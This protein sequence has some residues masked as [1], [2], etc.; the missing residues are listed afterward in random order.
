MKKF[1]AIAAMAAMLIACGE[2]AEETPNN[3]GGNNNEGDNTE[4]E[5]V[6]A[7]TV[8]GNFADW[9]ALTSGVSVATLPEG[10]Y[11][12]GLKEFKAY[13]DEYYLFIYGEYDPAVITSYDWTVVDIYLNIDGDET[14]GGGNDH[15]GAP[16]CSDY[17]I[18]GPILSAGTYDD[19]SGWAFALFPWASYVKDGIPGWNWS[20]LEEGETSSSDNGWGALIPEGNDSGLVSGVAG[21]GAKFE[22]AIFKEMVEEDA[23]ADTFSVGL[24]IDFGWGNVEGFLPQAA[25]TEENPE[26]EAGLLSVTTVK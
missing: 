20:A 19:Y 9:D 8:D 26:G 18:Q 23:W 4:Q 10:A 25:S 17:L 5:Y 21:T 22:L 2:P 12:T 6:A 7:I 13:C 3:G 24:D 1:F 11:L 14:T 16:H 15:F